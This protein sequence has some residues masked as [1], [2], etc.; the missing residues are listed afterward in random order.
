MHPALPSHPQHK[1]FKRDFSG[2]CGLFA[3]QLSDKFDQ[4]AA[5]VWMDMA[6]AKG[7]F[8]MGYSWG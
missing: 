8:G 7:M 5:D 6:I 1:I 2:A 4:Q 3:F